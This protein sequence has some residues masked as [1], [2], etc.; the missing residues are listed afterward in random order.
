MLRSPT[1]GSKNE[2]ALH[3]MH[4]D[5]RKRYHNT[6]KVIYDMCSTDVLFNVYSSNKKLSCIKMKKKYVIHVQVLKN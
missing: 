3:K 4:S 2:G 5:F 6:K 1:N